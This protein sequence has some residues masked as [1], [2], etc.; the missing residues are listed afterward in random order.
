MRRLQLALCRTAR[1]T[2]PAPFRKRGIFKN[3][4]DT[5]ILK[6]FRLFAE[7]RHRRKFGPVSWLSAPSGPG[8]Y[9]P[10]GLIYALF[11]IL[12]LLPLPLLHA[13]GVALGWLV[14]GVDRRYRARFC[15]NI[16]LIGADRR[17]RRRAIGEAGK[18]ITELAAIWGRSEAAV[19]RLVREVRGWDAIERCGDRGIVFLTPHLGCFEIASIFIAARRDLTVLYRKPKLAW[20]APVMQA[21]RARRG[22]SLAPADLSGVKMLLKSLKTQRSVG[23]LPD[24]VPSSGDGAWSS[25]FN[26]PAYTMTLPARLAAQTGAAV[27][28]VAAER[29]KR[30]RGYRL[31]FEAIELPP[32]LEAAVAFINQTVE[33]WAKRFPEQY[34]WS[35]NRYKAPPRA[36][37]GAQA[38]RRGSRGSA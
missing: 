18:S 3:K 35:Y 29:L 14:Y 9:Y 25:F 38:S 27:V 28:M 19:L 33:N 12:G 6:G 21:G 24:Q 31:H 1:V 5:L 16:A 10:R 20:L 7:P 17:L 11:R 13:L 2:N 22:V 32:D 30:G 26:R 34:L 36:T 37:S 15:E 23:I 8:L 4:R